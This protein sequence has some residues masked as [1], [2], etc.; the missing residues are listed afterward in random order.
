MT[1]TSQPA[2]TLLGL[3]R[4]FVYAAASAAS[5]ALPLAVLL[6]A[7]HRLDQDVY[8]R[9]SFALALATIGESLMDWGLHQVAV[10][11]VAQE[12]GRAGQ[13]F[14]NS[15]ALKIVPSLAMVLVL[16]AIGW[17]SKPEVDV[18]IACGLLAVSAM[19]R[20]YLMTVRGILLGL[21]R[22]GTDAVV[23]LLDRVLL[24]ALAAAVLY[25]GHGLITLGWAFVVSRT[26]ALAVA[27]AIAGGHVGS[28]APS[29]D[30]E[31]WRDLGQRAL[32]IGA[33]LILLN[34]YS[35]V[36]TLMLSLIATD[37]ETA[38][39]NAAYR[40]YEGVIYGAAVLSSVLTPRLSAEF[41][42]DRGRFVSLA[43]QGFAASI[44]IAGVCALCTVVLAHWGIV[45]L[46]GEPYATATGALH[47]LSASLLL[48][49]P[50][51]ILQAIAI[52]TSTEKVL[53]RATIVGVV[54]N[55]AANFFLIPAAG[56]NGA[57]LATVIGEVVNLLLLL[58][59]LGWALR[60]PSAS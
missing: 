56:R 13:V 6:L 47:I 26:I 14:R 10:R 31:L 33:F 24:L 42:R 39:Y 48:V 43:R 12:R 35:Y 38:L 4:N 52:S 41:V 53:I 36:D 60:R 34:L 9:F 29:F 8:G 20:S 45:F 15:I 18:R 32:P 17:I 54:V 16:T 1:D 19:M 21:E 27:F 40:I 59:G 11:S 7:A 37:T 44:G 46:F 28:V 3:S 55:V 2:P 23:M 5:A 50:I 49:F 58:Y 57:A 51:W 25:S 30:P 22:F